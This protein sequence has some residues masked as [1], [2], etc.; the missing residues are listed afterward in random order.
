MDFKTSHK[1]KTGTQEALCG[2][3]DVHKNM[4]TRVWGDVT[5]EECLKL[6]KLKTK[7]LRLSGTVHKS[8]HDGSPIYCKESKKENLSYYWKFVN[9][10]TCL[11]YQALPS[12]DSKLYRISS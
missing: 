6:K 2:K 5:C 8:N 3:K 11:K 10:K 9:C 12:H 4:I 1:R 7:N